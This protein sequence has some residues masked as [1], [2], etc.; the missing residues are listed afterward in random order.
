MAKKREPNLLDLI[1]R[2]V[3]AWEVTSEGN[4]DLIIPKFKYRGFQY[5]MNRLGKSPV[6][7]IHLDD[8]GSHVWQCCDGSNTVFTIG[9]N[10]QTAFGE[11]V[12]PV[13]DRLATF[14]RLLYHHKTIILS[15]K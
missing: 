12:E 5:L 2:R 13:F 6:V 11:R 3:V 9:H 15:N 14:I 8:F 10:L 4:I 7:R 1:P